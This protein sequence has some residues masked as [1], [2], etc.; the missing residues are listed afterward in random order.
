MG[1]FA[2]NANRQILPPRMRHFSLAEMLLL[3]AGVVTGRKW[4]LS[5]GLT[6]RVMELT[7][8]FFIKG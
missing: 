8:Y 4:N 2:K 5:H 3:R 1:L 7:E 6:R